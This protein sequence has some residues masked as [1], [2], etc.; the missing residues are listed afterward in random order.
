MSSVVTILESFFI[1][2]RRAKTTSQ[3]IPPMPPLCPLLP[4]SSAPTLCLYCVSLRFRVLQLKASSPHRNHHATPDVLTHPLHTVMKR[5]H[6]QTQ[7]IGGLVG[8]G[9]VILGRFIHHIYRNRL[10]TENGLL[11]DQRSATMC[12]RT[13]LFVQGIF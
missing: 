11:Q 6:I 5:T 10:K 9:S 1:C 3:N 4:T 13:S 12:L 8:F 2:T 7:T